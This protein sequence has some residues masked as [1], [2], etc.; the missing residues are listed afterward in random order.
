M[1][2]DNEKSAITTTLP[3]DLIKRLK[4]LCQSEGRNM[5]YYIQK[6]IEDGLDKLEK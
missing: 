4:E 2:K 1:Y 6:W 5:N 3:R